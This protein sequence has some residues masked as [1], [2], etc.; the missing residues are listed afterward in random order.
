MDTQR[1]DFKNIQTT[2][3]ADE[4]GDKAFDAESFPVPLRAG[5]PVLR[6]PVLVA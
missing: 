4:D 2:G 3:V 5:L 1:F 6:A